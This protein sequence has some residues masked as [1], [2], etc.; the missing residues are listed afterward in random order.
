MKPFISTLVAILATSTA[1]LALSTGTYDDQ[2]F[3]ERRA[4]DDD[5]S[6]TADIK[7]Q[8]QNQQ[9]S[10]NY[11]SESD[12]D[13]MTQEMLDQFPDSFGLIRGKGTPPPIPPRSRTPPPIPLRSNTQNQ[14]KSINY[15]SESDDDEMTQEAFDQLQTHSRLIRGKQDTT[16]IPLR[17]NAYRVSRNQSIMIQNLMVRGSTQEMLDPSQASFRE[18]GA[19][20]NLLLCLRCHPTPLLLNSEITSLTSSL[21]PKEMITKNQMRMTLVLNFKR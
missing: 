1:T 19:S 10:I 17:S 9:K 11:D 12:D 18:S 8:P 4:N 21:S 3:L 16:P 5:V 13:E 14:Q 15:D 6:S 20:S 7:Q 2:S